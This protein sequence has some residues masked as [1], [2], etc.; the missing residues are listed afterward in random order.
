MANRFARSIRKII[1]GIGARLPL[2]RFRRNQKG[3]TTI[4]FAMVVTPFMALM[5]AIIETAIVFFAGQ[6]LETAVGDSARLI[7]TGQAQQQGFDQNKFKQAVCSRVYAL[8]DCTNG[9]IVDVRKYTSFAAA[10]TGKPID[11]NGNLINDFAYQPG[12]PGDIVVVRIMYQWPVYVSFVGLN[13]ADM[14]NGK[15]LLIATS[16][17]RNEPYT[18]NGSC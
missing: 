11:A 4:E 18:A 13:L 10:Q 15:R 2:R 9:M 8:F 3:A 17:F 12:C 16:A 5:F 1:D 14:A 6:T 7:I